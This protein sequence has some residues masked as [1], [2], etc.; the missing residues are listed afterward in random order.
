MY[1]VRSIFKTENS[2]YI[3]IFGTCKLQ[4]DGETDTKFNIRLNNHR[5]FHTGDRMDKR[6]TGVNNCTR[7]NLH[8]HDG[9]T[10]KNIKCALCLSK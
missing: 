3:L 5:S 10:S 9:S 4:Y 1:D 2:I 7:E 8:F 6:W